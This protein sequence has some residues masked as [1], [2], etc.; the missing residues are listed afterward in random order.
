MIKCHAIICRL[1]ETFSCPLILYPQSVISLFF[2]LDLIPL[3]LP[4]VLCLD[5]RIRVT[6]GHGLTEGF[7]GLPLFFINLFL[8]GLLKRGAVFMRVINHLVVVAPQDHRYHTKLHEASPRATYSQSTAQWVGEYWFL[9]NWSLTQCVHYFR[10]HA[11]PLGGDG[12]V[13][14]WTGQ[15]TC[16]IVWKIHLQINKIAWQFVEMLQHVE[17]W[18][19]CRIW[20]FESSFHQFSNSLLYHFRFTLHYS[21]Q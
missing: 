11:Q 2:H 7:Y 19:L 16:W 14:F 20:V 21:Y 6:V 4:P 15:F 10:C 8:W 3:D 13:Y 12:V 17:K 18:C 1:L 9:T 5:P